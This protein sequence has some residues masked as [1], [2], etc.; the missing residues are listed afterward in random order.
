MSFVHK[1]FWEKLEEICKREYILL[2]IHDGVMKLNQ[3]VFGKEWMKSTPIGNFAV[4][5][6]E[7]NS[8]PL[9]PK[10]HLSGTLKDGSHHVWTFAH[11]LGHHFA[12]QENRDRSEEAADK[13][14]RYLAFK[15][16]P[17]WQRLL[18]FIEIEVYCRKIK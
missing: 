9:L 13:W 7:W 5:C 15:H 16:I 11:E 2:E 4:G 17:W 18:I 12:I 10:I 8:V 6:Y 14:R 3:E 1:R